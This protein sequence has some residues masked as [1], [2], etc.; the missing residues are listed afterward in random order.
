MTAEHRRIAVFGGAYNNWIATRAVLE[1]ARRR[2]CDGVWFIGDAGGFGPHPDRTVEVLREARG[3]GFVQGNYDDSVGNGAEDCACG[4]TDPRDNHFAQISYDYT[5]ANTSSEHRAWLAAMPVDGR[6]RLG[7]HTLLLCHGSPRKVNEFLWESTTPAGFV[8]HLCDAN[9][10][11][12]VVCTHTGIHW[13]RRLADG[14]GVVNVGAVGR[15]PN[16][17]NRE[18]W[19]AVLEVADGRVQTTFVPVAYDWRALVG[20][21]RAEGLPE[22]FVETIATGWWTTC[23]EILPARERVRGRL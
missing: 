5:L 15:P 4:Y 14:R 8:R 7:D 22:E 10:A 12:L 11:D 18:V 20:A 13:E 16:D 1:D 23:L 21:M 6:V 17:G 19:Y 9:E 3:L 2:G